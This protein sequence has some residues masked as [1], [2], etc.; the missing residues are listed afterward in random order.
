MTGV[1]KRNRRAETDTGEK[2]WEGGQTGRWSHEA[3]VEPN[4]QEGPALEPPGAAQPFPHLDFRLC[5]LDLQE[6]TFLSF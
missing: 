2:P 4:R 1:L 5:L 6:N 3:R